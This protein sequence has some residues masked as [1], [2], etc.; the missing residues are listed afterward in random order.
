MEIRAIT[1]ADHDQAIAMMEDFYRSPAV[2]HRV[3]PSVHERSFWAAVEGGPF[4]EGFILEEGGQTAG[5]AM[6]SFTYSCEVGGRVALLEELYFKEE[7]RGK[8]LGHQYFQWA[9]RRYGRMARLRLEV[10]AANPRARS[11]YERLGFQVLDYTQMVK[12]RSL[13]E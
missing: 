5:Y 6:V 13:G 11:L 9:F 2:S 10:T 3:P 1:P 7:F 4:L 12:D 8:G